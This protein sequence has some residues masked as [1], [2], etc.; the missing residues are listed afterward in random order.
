[1][2]KHSKSHRKFKFNY[3][4][5]VPENESLPVISGRFPKVLYWY[6]PRV[7][8]FLKLEQHIM[9]AIFNRSNVTIHI[10]KIEEILKW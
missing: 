9:D 7:K 4:G 3:L 6:T 10:M 2:F 8:Y 5:A 1:M